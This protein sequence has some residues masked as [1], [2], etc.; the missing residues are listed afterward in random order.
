MSKYATATAFLLLMALEGGCRSPHR[1]TASCG[2]GASARTDTAGNGQ[3]ESTP[4]TSQGLRALREPWREIP[5]P[6]QQQEVRAAILSILN[7]GREG[8]DATM[9]LRSMGVGT[10]GPLIEKFT[11]WMWPDASRRLT[12][13]TEPALLMSR[14]E[15]SRTSTMM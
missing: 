15:R 5:D 13:S 14:Y 9:R 2:P 4:W 8:V 10:A 1:T 3:A 6:E 7:A 12:D 11:R